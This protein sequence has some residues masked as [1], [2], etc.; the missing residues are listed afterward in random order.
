ML[1]FKIT[2][3]LTQAKYGISSFDAKSSILVNIFI[4][5]RIINQSNKISIKAKK[6]LHN[7]KNKTDHKAFSAS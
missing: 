2:A 3:K 6:G 1:P 5:S 7:P 4:V